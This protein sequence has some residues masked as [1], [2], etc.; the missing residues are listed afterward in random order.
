MRITAIYFLGM[1]LLYDGQ[2]GVWRTQ[3]PVLRVNNKKT[4]ACSA[5]KTHLYVIIADLKC[6]D[7]ECY[8]ERLVA[9]PVGGEGRAEDG[10]APRLDEVPL[11][12]HQLL[13]HLVRHQHLAV[14]HLHQ[15]D[16]RMRSFLT[17]L[18]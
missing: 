17:S 9:A 4:G 16:R 8:G 10:G 13:H 5:A 1:K 7:L 18:N 12:T 3:R 15:R 6:E 14:T 2:W 11:L